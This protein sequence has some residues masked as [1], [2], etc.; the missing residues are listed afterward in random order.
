MAYLTNSLGWD[1]FAGSES[2]LGLWTGVVRFACDGQE[3]TGIVRC[4]QRHFDEA[5]ALADARLLAR[6]WS[7]RLQ[8]SPL[9]TRQSAEAELTAGTLNYESPGDSFADTEIDVHCA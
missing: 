1:V 5:D 4:A 6:E 7:A 3:T 2:L 9:S 8:G